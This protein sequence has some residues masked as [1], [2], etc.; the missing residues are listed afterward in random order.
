MTATIKTEYQ[1]GPVALFLCLILAAHVMTAA[2]AG[3]VVTCP[4]PGNSELPA[5][6]AGKYLAVVEGQPEFWKLSE[7]AAML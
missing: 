2:Y 3:A 4:S 1:K 7:F 5:D 6:A